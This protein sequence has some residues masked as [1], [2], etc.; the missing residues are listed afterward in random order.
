[1]VYSFQIDNIMDVYQYSSLSY[2]TAIRVL[3]VQILKTA[4]DSTHPVSVFNLEE[5]KLQDDPNYEALSYTWGETTYYDGFTYQWDSGPP[6]TYP[7]AIHGSG[8]LQ[9]TRNLNEFLQYLAKIAPIGTS[10]R[11]IWADQMCINQKNIDERNS[12]VA[13]MKDIYKSARRTLIWL[14]EQ[15]ADTLSVLNL[16]HAV[17]VPNVDRNQKLTVTLLQEFQQKVTKVLHAEVGMF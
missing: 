8:L 5:T 7:I 12:Q 9:V 14:G 13:M 1:M 2:P 11:R 16:L 3:V 15:D 4:E 10:T 6:R 17:D